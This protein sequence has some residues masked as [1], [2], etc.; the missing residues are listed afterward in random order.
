M[1]CTHV[2]HVA[3]VERGW[4]LMA[5]IVPSVKNPRLEDIDGINKNF[6]EIRQKMNCSSSPFRTKK[7]A[8]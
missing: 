3:L 1:T 2:T 6:N 8:G 5:E 7:R 4:K